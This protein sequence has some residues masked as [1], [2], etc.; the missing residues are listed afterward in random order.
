M[1]KTDKL[2]LTK[3][4][5]EGLTEKQRAIYDKM[6]S[7]NS[8]QLAM[9]IL[10]W[11]NAGEYIIGT[12]KR[13]M[14]FTGGSF[15]ESCMSY[16]FDTGEGLVSAVLGS[17]ADKTLAFEENIGRDFTIIFLG[18]KQGAVNKRWFNDFSIRAN[19]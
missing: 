13:F 14:P 8:E 18:K 4:Q 9:Q 15:D 5:L 7:G 16:I 1:A 6:K 2:E 11:E 3:E 17:T 12:L 10:K 19:I